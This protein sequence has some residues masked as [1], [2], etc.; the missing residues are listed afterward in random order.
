[1]NILK[2]FEDVEGR[3]DVNDIYYL[4]WGGFSPSLPFLSTSFYPVYFRR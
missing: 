4:I 3:R 2:R 1:M